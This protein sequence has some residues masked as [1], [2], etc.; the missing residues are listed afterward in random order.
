[1]TIAEVFIEEERLLL[2]P[3]RALFW[4]K[5]Q[6]LIVADLHLGKAT[7]FR[8][9]GIAVP[10]D[11]SNLNWDKLIG[12]LL[13]FQPQRLL[14]LGDLFHSDYNREWEELAAL[15]RQFNTVRFELIPGN[16][17]VLRPERYSDAGLLVHPEELKMGPF[18]LAHHPPEAP[19]PAS[20]PYLLAGHIHPS[21]SLRGPG[22]QHL[23]LPCFFF[24]STYGILPA[25][26]AFTGTARI[27][28]SAGDRIFVITGDK[29]LPL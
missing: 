7:H 23:R 24:G 6:T 16:H 20:K 10:P 21:V 26:G 12:L 28:P 4:E 22:R 3:W 14:F 18:L 25:F 9:A 1:M 13:H 11:V 17:D 15:I 8:R 5:E 29:V 2:H 19:P 27:R